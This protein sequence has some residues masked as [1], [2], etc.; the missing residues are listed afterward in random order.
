M[1][2]TRA[3]D[4]DEKRVALLR[5]AAQVFAAE[6]YD[7]ASMQAAAEAA[8][9]SKALVYH[10]FASKEALLFELIRGHLEG[11]AEAAEAAVAAAGP[12]PRARLHA[13]VAALLEA[14]RDADAEHKLQLSALSAL[15]EPRQA[16]I[17]ALER[18]LV[19]LMSR[20]V[21]E[22]APALPAAQ[23]RPAVMS[24]F[25]TINWAWMWFRDGG[26]MTRDAYAAFVTDLF[27]DGAAGARTER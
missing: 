1:A 14:Y 21:A 24:L 17:R 15:P 18:R 26:P 8:G 27:L 13:L 5:A 11:L 19:A 10:Y 22:A 6:G 20:A 2:R 3:K 4:H 16:E 23:L 12:A 7:R 9:V 25:G